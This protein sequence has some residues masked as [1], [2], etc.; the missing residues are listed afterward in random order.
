MRTEIN[1][2]CQDC[3]DQATTSAVLMVG[4][5]EM[6]TNPENKKQARLYTCPNCDKHVTVTFRMLLN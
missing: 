6:V 2:Y 3:T 4:A 5:E 1:V